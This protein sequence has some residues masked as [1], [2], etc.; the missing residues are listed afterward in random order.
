MRVNGAAHEVDAALE[1]GVLLVQQGDG[2]L[3]VAGA[4]G[5]RIE[6]HETL[7]VVASLCRPIVDSAPMLA[8]CAR[9]ATAPAS[10]KR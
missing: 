8:S 2:L 9:S 1:R 3:L 10:V 4:P 5:A 6:A 7:H